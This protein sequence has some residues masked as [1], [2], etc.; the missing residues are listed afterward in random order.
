MLKS[1]EA[2]MRSLN[3]EGRSVI[4]GR[5]GSKQ[6]WGLLSWAGQQEAWN[7]LPDGRD[8]GD[9]LRSG[10]LTSLPPT[11]IKITNTGTYG[12]MLWDGAGGFSFVS[13]RFVSA[14]QEAGFGGFQ[15]LPLEVQPK[16]GERFPGYSLLL[17]DN[18]DEDAPIRSSPFVYR[19]TSWLDVS[20]EA[21]AALERAGVTAFDVT[22]AAKDAARYFEDRL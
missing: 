22:D 18:K 16:R 17:P 19:S 3:Y 20:A 4:R 1:E 14:I 15:L 8:V 21:L 11:W 6:A 7:I 9:V 5:W 2:I 12:D 10:D 13:E